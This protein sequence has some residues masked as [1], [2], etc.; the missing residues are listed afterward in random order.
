[1]AASPCRRRLAA[2]KGSPTAV[3]SG[4][5]KKESGGGQKKERRLE[6]VLLLQKKR[7]GVAVWQGCKLFPPFSKE[8]MECFLS[9]FSLCKK[10]LKHKTWSLVV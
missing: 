1:V 9:F 2:A 6:A 8:E 10:R 4:E 7:I 3:W 5:R